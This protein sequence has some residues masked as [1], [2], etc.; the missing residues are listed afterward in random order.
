MWKA[1]LHDADPWIPA[2]FG[3]ASLGAIRGATMPVM[4][5]GNA[6]GPI[7]AAAVFDGPL[8]HCHIVNSRGNGT[9]SVGELLPAAKQTP[10]PVYG[11]IGLLGDCR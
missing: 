10:Q 4:L 6:V 5:G 9:S 8:D 7:L 2:H 1:G 3:R 11:N